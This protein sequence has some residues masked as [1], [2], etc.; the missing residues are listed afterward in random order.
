[1]AV[2][3]VVVVVAAGMAA[4]VVVVSELVVIEAGSIGTV[5]LLVVEGQR[6][7]SIQSRHCI[8]S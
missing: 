7:R 1:M 8:W 3:G 4:V 2:V 5:A 6:M